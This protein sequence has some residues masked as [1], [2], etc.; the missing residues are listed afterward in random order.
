[1]KDKKVAMTFFLSILLLTACSPN[2]KPEIEYP[3]SNVAIEYE[4]DEIKISNFEDFGYLNE[5]YHLVFEEKEQIEVFIDAIE[6][7]DP[8]EGSVNMPKGDYNLFLGSSEGSSEGFHLWISEIHPN[9]TI[10][11][12]EDTETA[13]TLTDRSRN[14][15]QVL[16]S[17]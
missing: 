10:M 11:K 8:V 12:I 17:E 1:M 7:A 14:K 4:V 2:S 3:Y 15:I 9:G 16:L 6:S 5:D 13:Y